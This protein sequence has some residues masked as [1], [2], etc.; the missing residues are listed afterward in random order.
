MFPDVDFDYDDDPDL[1]DDDDEQEYWPPDA[2]AVP[3]D[4][5]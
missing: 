3:E 5:C 1:E 4:V 2:V